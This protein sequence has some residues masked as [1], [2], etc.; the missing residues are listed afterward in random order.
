MT[1]LPPPGYRL[2]DLAV[3]ASSASRLP[4]VPFAGPAQRAA[5]ARLAPTSLPLLIQGEPGSGLRWIARWVHA[6]SGR[7][8]RVLELD[9][10]SPAR[11]PGPSTA[12]NTKAA[13][14][15]ARC[16]TLCVRDLLSLPRSW[17]AALAA[18]IDVPSAG[19]PR[20]VGCVAPEWL[21]LEV[22]DQGLNDRFMD[23]DLTPVAAHAADL[24][25]ILEFFLSLYAERAGTPAPMLCEVSRTRLASYPWPGDLEEVEH[26]AERAVALGSVEHALTMLPVDD[27]VGRARSAAAL[28]G[29]TRELLAR[30]RPIPLGRVQQ[31]LVHVAER[32]WVHRV[33]HGVRGDRAAAARALGISTEVLEH[34]FSPSGAGGGAR[35]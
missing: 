9:A 4:A 14:S 8:G 30:G 25:S 3:G 27:P 10:S 1:Q 12:M 19:G 22:M 33:L 32:A 17:R 16:G 6:V 5:L 7:P 11:G 26:F 20:I 18:E 35:P 34:R 31:R 13:L 2:R 21:P 24:A 15:M 29:L 28:W 23:V